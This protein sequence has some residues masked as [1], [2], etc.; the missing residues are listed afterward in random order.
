VHIDNAPIHSS[1]I[2]QNFFGYNPLKRFP[3]PSFSTDVFLSDFDLCGKVKSALIWR[4][5]PDES[6]LLEA[7]TEILND[8]SDDELQCFFRSWIEC[9]KR[10]INVGGD[11]LSE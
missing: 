11:H 10:A 5:I 6:D 2:T 3:R 4:E 8:I 7:V 9:A 1:R